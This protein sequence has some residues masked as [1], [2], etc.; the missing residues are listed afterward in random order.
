[1]VEGY[2][3]RRELADAP[4]RV[5][6]GHRPLVMQ[7]CCAPRAALEGV[8]VRLDQRPKVRACD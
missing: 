4:E 6:P 1:M 2:A 7:P 5:I 8:V 3:R